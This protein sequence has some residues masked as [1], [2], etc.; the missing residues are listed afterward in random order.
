MTIKGSDELSLRP[1]RPG[2]PSLSNWGVFGD[3]DEVGTL[4]YLTPAAVRRGA[5]CV[6]TGVAYPLNMPADLPKNRP[7]RRPDLVKTAHALNLRL[8]DAIMNDDH[9]L[10][11]TQGSSQWDAFVH[12]GMFEDGVDGAFYNGVSTEDV[13]AQGYA[14]RGGIDKLAQRG[15]VGRG[16]MLDIARM[17]TDGSTEPL[18]LDFVIDENVYRRCIQHEGIEIAS[19]DIV[20]F[21][22][23][24]SEKYLAAHDTEREA[25]MGHPDA[26]AMRNP[27][28]SP[29]MTPFIHAERWAAVAADNLAVEAV[30]MPAEFADSIHI[31]VLRNLGLPLGE[32]FLFK[33]L[34]EA[35]AA[36]HRWEFQFI[37]VPMWIPGGMGSPANAIGIC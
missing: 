16:V 12:C 14:H 15:I 32:I 28:L 27:G 9:V 10:L 7:V 31:R 34:S 3:D 5:D 4:N 25:L 21:R 33:D 29:D 22:T 13:D 37:A 35:C 30:P 23:G 20:C 8:G 1:P 26:T 24:W 18:P 6:K 36:E 11:A 17:V 2:A 19:G